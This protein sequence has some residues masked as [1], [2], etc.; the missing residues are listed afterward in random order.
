MP[1]RI[2]SIA[3]NTFTESIRQP[4]Y[5]VVLGLTIFLLVLELFWSAYTFD[6]D[7]KILIEFCLST[8]LAGG[9]V[10][11]SLISSGVLAREIEN[12]T[13]LTVISKP[14]GRPAFIFGKYLGVIAA[15]AMAFWVWSLIS[16]MLIRHSVMSTASD[17]VD[18][19]VFLF[20]FGALAIAIAAATWG[21]Y[22]YNWVWTS[23]MVG[24]FTVAL[25]IGYVLVLV[26]SPKWQFQPIT[27]EF[28]KA[29]EEGRAMLGEVVLAL[30]LVFEALTILCAVAIACS[31]RLGQVLTLLTC[32]G[33]FGLGSVS[34]WAFGRFAPAQ[35]V[36]PFDTALLP[37][38][39]YRVTPNIGYL[40][41]ADALSQQA[42]VTAGYVGITT[43]YTVLFTTAIL[44]LAVA[45]F[46]TRETG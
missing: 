13:A 1:Q 37:W 22:F 24:I 12:K 38:V 31:T 3:R 21:N 23:K 45:L 26:I 18:M 8:V 6:E 14:I 10:M 15:V 44:C 43:A 5:L 25:T 28:T 34:D 46:Q 32:I 2:F 41:V 17:K 30:L 11:A 39:A 36:P 16:L 40:F 20:G 42:P 4:I 33:V 7:D 29:G 19:P 9:V 35:N 27:T